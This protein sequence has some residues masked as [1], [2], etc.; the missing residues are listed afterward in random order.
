MTTSKTRRPRLPGPP[1]VAGSPSAGDLRIAK[2]ARSAG[3]FTPIPE[4]LEAIRAGG[5]VVVVDD[6]D[7][8]NE[9]DLTVAA[10]KVTPEIVNFMATHGRGLVCLA[11]TPERLDALEIP[12]EVP[13]NSSLR[14]T[15]MCV[16]IDARDKTS[17]GTPGH[18]P[19]ICCD[20]AMCSPCARGRAACWCGR[21]TPRPR[22]TLRR[23]PAS[24]RQGSS[25]RS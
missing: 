19:K 14:E 2:G 13:V 20:R 25:A 18:G 6:E 22:S 17:T 5:L 21:V 24:R 23:L 3:P 10:E 9:G 11:L 16:S 7:R 1:V 12:L 4:A 15:A 8:E